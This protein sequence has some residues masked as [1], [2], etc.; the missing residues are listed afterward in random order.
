MPNCQFVSSLPDSLQVTAPRF[1]SVILAG[2][3]GSMKFWGVNDVGITG[4]KITFNPNVGLSS[5]AYNQGRN[6]HK[7]KLTTAA[8][9]TIPVFPPGC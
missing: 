5:E 1:E 7:L 4:A 2:Q 8:S 9:V 3:V 6:L